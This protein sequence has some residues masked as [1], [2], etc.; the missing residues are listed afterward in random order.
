MIYVKQ[1]QSSFDLQ[2]S[3]LRQYIVEIQ[4]LL[5]LTHMN[6]IP[7]AARVHDELWQQVS[8]EFLPVQLVTWADRE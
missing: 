8:A 6:K 2:D 5:I 1:A 4:K 3:P 7:P